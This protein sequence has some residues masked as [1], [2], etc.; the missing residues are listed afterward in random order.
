MGNKF[1]FDFGTRISTVTPIE[2]SSYC[3][4][5]VQL[6][7]REPQ[8][9]NFSKDFKNGTSRVSRRA[10][11]NIRELALKRRAKS[12]VSFI[13]AVFVLVFPFIL[14]KSFE[15][16]LKSLSSL[17]SSEP[18]AYLNLPF[19]FYALFGILSLGLFANGIYFWKRA[20]HADQG[21]KGEEEIGLQV[22]GLEREGWTIEY[23]ISQAIDSE[24]LIL[25]AC[26]LKRKPT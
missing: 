10:G 2:K 13:A 5:S 16:F 12:V 21:A 20:N 9:S 19:T 22:S 1:P 24:M 8:K 3:N 14:V 17:S 18:Q 6:M 7:I 4:F 23:G 26:L 11:Q 25:F 15:D